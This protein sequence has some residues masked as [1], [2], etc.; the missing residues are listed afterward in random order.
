AASSG[1]IVTM[2]VN[3][4]TVPTFLGFPVQLTP[5]LPQVGT[6]LNSIM[7]LF[8]DLSLAA[9]VGERRGI[10]IRVSSERLLDTDQLLWRGTERFDIVNHDLGDASVAGPVVGLMGN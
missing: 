5:V 1:G 6:A 7:L 9:T 3:G 8:G 2:T 10:S 4:V